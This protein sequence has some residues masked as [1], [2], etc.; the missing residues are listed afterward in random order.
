LWLKSESNRDDL[1]GL[2]IPRP[3]QLMGKETRG[4]H[5]VAG[6]HHDR[7]TVCATVLTHELPWIQ[8][9]ERGVNTIYRRHSSRHIADVPAV[10]G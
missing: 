1:S 8:D 7:L 2:I 9:G 10:L 4:H 6:A 3:S 5:L